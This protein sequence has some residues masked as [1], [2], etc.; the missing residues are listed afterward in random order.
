[1][2]N[3]V[4]RKGKLIEHLF[5]TLNGLSYFA[6]EYPKSLGK[7]WVDNNVFPLIQGIDPVDMLRTFT[8]HIAYQVA[9]NLRGVTLASGGGV[10]N[11]FLMERIMHLA[12]HEIHVPDD[13][14]I[15]YKEALVFAFLGLLRY[16]K[17][18]N[19]L[20]SVT[21]SSSDHSAGS[22]HMPS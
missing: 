21:G 9:K 12:D 4:A 16:R 20:S 15:Q 3:R 7:E 19:V 1:M 13:L 14:T 10:Y 8:E 6:E 11:S 17:E 22:I 2:K 18:I 5:D